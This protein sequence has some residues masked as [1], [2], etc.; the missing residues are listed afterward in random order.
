MKQSS[1][2]TSVESKIT[3]PQLTLSNFYTSPLGNSTKQKKKMEHKF[4]K[5]FEEIDW[6]ST[7]SK[8][9]GCVEI[10][11]VKGELYDIENITI[12]VVTSFIFT[13]TK[14]SDEYYEVAW[15]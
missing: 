11:C 4:S 10:T 7:T 8:V 3:V 5:Y 13:C 15:I 14:G 1:I 12:P 2:I 9:E 6:S